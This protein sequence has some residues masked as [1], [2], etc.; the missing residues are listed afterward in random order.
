M[1]QPAKPLFDRATRTPRHRACITCSVRRTTPLTTRFATALFMHTR[2]LRSYKTQNAPKT[3]LTTP[4]PNIAPDQTRTPTYTQRAGRATAKTSVPTKTPRLH[5][6]H[7]SKYQPTTKLLLTVI[8]RRVPHTPLFT[9]QPRK[10][11]RVAH[12]PAWPSIGC[13]LPTKRTTTGP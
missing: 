2:P 8:R 12:L 6:N 7:T 9:K 5:P 11:F 10:P 3:R 13:S 1:L 4:T